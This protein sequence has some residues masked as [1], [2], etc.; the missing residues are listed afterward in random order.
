MKRILYCLLC[1]LSCSASAQDSHYWNLQYGAKATLLGGTVIGSVSDL[2]AT[3]YNPGAISL[4]N[5]PK[6][7]LS[8]KVYQ[9][10]NFKVIDGAGEN[11]DLVFSS[12]A[13]A[14]SFVA[15]NIKIDSTGKNKMAF[16]ILSRQAMRFKFET[17]QSTVDPQSTGNSITSGGFSLNQDFD[18]IWGGLSYSRKLN[19]VLGLGMTAY[20]AYRSQNSRFQTAIEELQP[21]NQ[22]AS[23]LVFRDLN[24][25]NYRTLVKAGLAVNL[26]P[27][28]LGLTITTPSL[29]IMGSG[30]YGYNN[31][32]SD[33]DSASKNIY[34]SNWQR[35]L[36]SKLNSSWAIGLGA[37]YWR[38]KFTLHVSAEWFDAVKKYHPITLE[39][40][41]AQSSGEAIQ[42]EIVQEF[43][44]VI[45]GGIGMDYNIN[46]EVS[47]SASVITDFSANIEDPKSNI[48]FTRWD[49]YHFS[50]G[51][52][53]GIGKAE[54]TLGFS[55]S[56]GNDQIKQ[57]ANI[58][59]PGKLGSIIKPETEVQFT[60]IKILF[61]IIL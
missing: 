42:N 58:E 51:S 46:K 20:G 45:N 35:D 37:A 59:N 7:I 39:P 2:S 52:S 5:D 19:S 43:N 24:F 33:P 55:Y 23:L 49:I 17:A 8:A 13:P 30:S 48:S 54:I 40:F 44:S 10:E 25:E 36:K 56:F 6:L 9:Y 21:N 26:K 27:I 38:E 11:K 61:G 14:P 32:V 50:A 34:E 31:F 1:I 18:E 12:I 16:S 4:F 53:F 22:M 15:F 29:N 47:V 28:T 41:Y 3:Y 60:R 57:I